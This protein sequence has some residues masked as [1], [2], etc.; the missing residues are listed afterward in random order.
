MI[1]RPPKSTRT[2]PLFPY[3]TLFRSGKAPRQCPGRR[4]AVRRKTRLGQ[5]GSGSK[6]QIPVMNL[7]RILLRQSGLSLRLTYGCRLHRVRCL[8][9]WEREIMGEGR[10]WNRFGFHRSEEHTSELK[11]LM[12]ISYAHVC[13]KKKTLSTQLNTTIPDYAI[14]QSST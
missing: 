6:R 11:S 7:G 3:P 8:L 1:R 14:V 12:R 13:L 10:R 2:A 9:L 4:S 5:F